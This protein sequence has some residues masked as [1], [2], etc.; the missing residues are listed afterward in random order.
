MPEAFVAA[1]FLTA[2][3]SIDP[4]PIALGRVK[5][6]DAAAGAAEARPIAPRR[7]GRIGR[8]VPAAVL[9]AVTMVA[10]A[11]EAQSQP[12]PTAAATPAETPIC[13][14]RPAKANVPCTVPAGDVQIEAD[15]VNWSRAS[16]DG[17]SA[18][19]LLF[20][21]PTLKYGVLANLDVEVDWAP[22]EQVR[23]TFAGRTT[24]ASSVGDLFLRAKWAAIGGD[25]VSLSLIPYVKLPTASHDVGNGHVEGGL[26]APISVSLPAKFTLALGPELD[27]LENADRT[28]AHVNVVN[29]VDVNRSFGKWT[30]YGELWNEQTFDPRGAVAQTTA[31]AAVAYLLTSTLQLDAGANFGL[32]RNAPQQQY[33]LGVSHRF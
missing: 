11:A 5:M 12:P 25:A 21:N 10:G 33:Y 26:I 8:L 17:A 19:T 29:V 2:P 4:H 27:A 24:T 16:A 31:D 18:R 15:L 23:T 20:T 13:T 28:G 1:R 22:W 30:V 32:D 7:P 6:T 3:Q 9:A 14:D